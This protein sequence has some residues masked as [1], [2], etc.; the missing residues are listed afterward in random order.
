MVLGLSDFA[1]ED[2]IQLNLPDY[3]KMSTTQML[4]QNNMNFLTQTPL[5]REPEKNIAY[6]LDKATWTLFFASLMLVT[7]AFSM[8]SK[9]NVRLIIFFS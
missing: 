4:Y 5:E 3:P 7:L 1:I 2:P 8:I 6:V 9:F